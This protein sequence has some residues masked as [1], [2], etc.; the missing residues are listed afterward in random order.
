MSSRLIPPND[1][2]IKRTALMNASASSVSNSRSMEFTSA[3]RLKRTDF[4]SITGFD[5]RAP[6]F[7]KPK[8]AEPLV[9]TATMLPLVV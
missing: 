5:A 3:K 6:R 7:P 2:P 1:G 4:P 8:I 9:I